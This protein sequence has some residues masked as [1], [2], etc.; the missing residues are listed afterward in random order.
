MQTDKQVTSHMKEN[1][2]ETDF[3]CNT[4]LFNISW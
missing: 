3:T 4:I 1:L 2:K